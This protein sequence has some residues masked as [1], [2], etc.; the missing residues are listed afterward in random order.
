MRLVKIRLRIH[1]IRVLPLI[2]FIQSL[3]ELQFLLFEIN[4][5]NS[6]LHIPEPHIGV[7]HAARNGGISLPCHDR[8]VH[9]P[10][11]CVNLRTKVLKRGL[12]LDH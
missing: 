3:E 4:A 5:P 7:D 1:L 9:H 2:D 6:L 12:L 8:L 10:L 11:K